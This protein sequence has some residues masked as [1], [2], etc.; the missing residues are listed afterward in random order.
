MESRLSSVMECATRT[1]THLDGT[2][3]L[4][5]VAGEDFGIA[6]WGCGASRQGE[7]EGAIRY[8]SW[9]RSSSHDIIV[10]SVARLLLLEMPI[11]SSQYVAIHAHQHAPVSVPSWKGTSNT[12][13]MFASENCLLRILI[14]HGHDH[15]ALHHHT[16]LFVCVD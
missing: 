10:C 9:S 11:R 3:M 12:S 6:L 13:S 15:V 14:F 5:S 1:R 2:A 4:R 16:V 8:A 7:E